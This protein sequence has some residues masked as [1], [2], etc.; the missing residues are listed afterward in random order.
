M[1]QAKVGDTV[2]VHYKVKL[3]DGK[4]FETSVNRE[5]LQ[6]KIGEGKLIPGFEQAVAGMKPGES[7]TTTIPWKE[8]YG[9]HHHELV[10][11]VERKDFPVHINPEVGLQ[12]RSREVHGREI[13]FTIIGISESSVTLDANHPLAGK[14]ITFDIELLSIV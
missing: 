12:L 4:L 7:K 10:K 3:E 9:P 5:P 6:F 13:V 14:D 1:T 11:V 8:A 2:K